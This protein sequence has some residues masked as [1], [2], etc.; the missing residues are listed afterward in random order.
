MLIMGGGQGFCGHTV[1]SNIVS[2]ENLSNIDGGSIFMH[3]CAHA[4]LL[5][6]CSV[7]F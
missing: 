7:A 5:Q 3:M 6:N 4:P 2:P 1:I